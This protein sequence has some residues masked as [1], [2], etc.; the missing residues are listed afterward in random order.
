VVILFYPP[1][2]NTQKPISSASIKTPKT[3]LSLFWIILGRF[4][5]VYRHGAETRKSM[6][7]HA[8]QVSG[9]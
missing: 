7:P 1:S 2:E 5:G 4:R 3:L 9:L 8:V 6:E